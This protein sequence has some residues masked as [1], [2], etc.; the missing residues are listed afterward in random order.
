MFTK[1]ISRT[2]WREFFGTFSRKHKGWLVDLQI[3]GSDIGAQ[4]EGRALALEG[5]IYER[6]GSSRDTII[7][8]IG[9][10]PNDHITHTISRPLEVNLEQTDEG[11]DVALAI[12]AADGTTALLSFRSAALPETVDAV[13]P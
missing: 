9:G 12:K 8:M 6:D 7:L 13:G 3:L 10:R 5:V 11:A 2:E 1:P 4:V